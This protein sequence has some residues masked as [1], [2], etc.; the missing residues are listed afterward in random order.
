MM[1]A[2]SDDFPTYT[3]WMIIDSAEKIQRLHDKTR[4][5]RVDTPYHMYRQ[6]PATDAARFLLSPLPRC[7][8][9]CAWTRRNGNDNA[10][11]KRQKHEIAQRTLRN[12]D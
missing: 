3:T 2:A 4:Q 11:R 7:R 1:N 5:S 9:V 10:R 12:R 6:V 8:S